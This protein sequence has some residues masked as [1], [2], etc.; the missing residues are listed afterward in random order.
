MVEQSGQNIQP[1][2]VTAV[3]RQ[4]ATTTLSHP[5]WAA[6]ELVE[7]ANF[8]FPEIRRSFFRAN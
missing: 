2:A 3:K 4:T 1:S 7:Y 8:Q 5:V 6:L